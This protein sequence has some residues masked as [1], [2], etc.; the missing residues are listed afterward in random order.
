MASDFQ[1]EYLLR[2]PL[3]LAQRYGRLARGRT[4]EQ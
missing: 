1:R 3:P 2:L 4:H